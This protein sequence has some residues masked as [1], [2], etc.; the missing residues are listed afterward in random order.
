[1]EGK[2]KEIKYCPNCKAELV[3][4]KNPN[5]NAFKCTGCLVRWN[6]QYL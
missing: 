2:N 6:I 5:Y 3:K 1:M 4:Y